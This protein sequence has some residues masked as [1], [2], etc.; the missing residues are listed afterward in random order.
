MS[1]NENEQVSKN[2]SKKNMREI[3]S[4]KVLFKIKKKKNSGNRSNNKSNKYNYN[5]VY[6][7]SNYTAKTFNQKSKSNM[8]KKNNDL[9]NQSINNATELENNAV[10]CSNFAN[11]DINALVNEKNKLKIISNF[12]ISNNQ[13]DDNYKISEIKNLKMDINELN[14]SQN[15]NF[16]KNDINNE[17]KI[18]L[19]FNENKAENKIVNKKDNIL[20][21]KLNNSGKIFQNINKN[22]LNC[23]K[24]IIEKNKNKERQKSSKIFKKMSKKD[25]IKNLKEKKNVE[26]Y[27]NK[28]KKKYLI[29]DEKNNS[30]E[31]FEIIENDIKYNN[32]NHKE[33]L[34]KGQ[35]D[36][37]NTQ[38][39]DKNVIKNEFKNTLLYNDIDEKFKKLYTKILR[40]KEDSKNDETIINIENNTIKSNNL[41]HITYPKLKRYRQKSDSN[42]RIDRN[43]IKNINEI[44]ENDTTTKIEYPIINNTNSNLTKF[45]TLEE[46]IKNENSSKR[47]INNLLNKKINPEFK[48]ILSNLKTAMNKFPKYEER[49]DN[50]NYLSTLPANYLSPFDTFN[51]E[52]NNKRISNLKLNIFN[53]NYYSEGINYN[54]K[55]NEKFQSAFD[56]FKKIINEKNISKNIINKGRN[57]DKYISKTRIIYSNL[58]PVN[59]LEN[60]L[61]ILDS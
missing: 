32:I 3:D 30:S 2:K 17:N 49:K 47:M 44:N 26:L 41:F 45:K 9:N 21:I 4:Y 15:Q 19:N 12:N 40:K 18:R 57:G 36:N 25:N 59:N 33:I 39:Y 8:I 54:N 52:K 37:N 23:M 10:S 27:K 43:K 22:N 29:D 11:S 53:N 35:I 7:R 1:Q 51:Y 6:T 55:K 13:N 61:F 42:I 16:D 48:E 20:E 46:K 5:Y 24:N 56:N 38:I 14:S 28:N 58:C 34:I 31:N 60:D 50:N